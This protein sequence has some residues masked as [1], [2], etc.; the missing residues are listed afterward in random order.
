M[1]DNS[2]TSKEEGSLVKDARETDIVIPYVS[3]D[4]FRHAMAELCLSVSW[5]RRVLGKALYAPLST[6]Y[7]PYDV[8]ILI[9]YQHTLGK[10]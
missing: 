1:A 2:K 9:V 6:G 3:T 8:V 10:R 7:A 4:Q 5:A